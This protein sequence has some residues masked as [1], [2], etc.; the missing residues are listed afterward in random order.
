M[1]KGNDIVKT[2]DVAA[3]YVSETKIKIDVLGFVDACDKLQGFVDKMYSPEMRLMEPLEQFHKHFKRKYKISLE[4]DIEHIF[5]IS[6]KGCIS[7][8]S[9][10]T[11]FSLKLICCSPNVTMNKLTNAGSRSIIVTSGTLAPMTSYPMTW[12]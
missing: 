1:E 4:L 9:K 3:A 11:D 2:L 12:K 7:R 10:T 6:K 8:T 5:I